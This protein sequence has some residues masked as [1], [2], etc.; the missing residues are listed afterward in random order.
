[1]ATLRRGLV[2]LLPATGFTGLYLLLLSTI[3]LAEVVVAVTIG[4]VS[5]AA[6]GFAARTTGTSYAPRARWAGWLVSLPGAIGRDTIA[7]IG[8][9]AV[10]L[11]RLRAARGGGSGFDVESFDR[12]RAGAREEA[13]GPRWRA[14]ATLVL[15]TAPGTYVAEVEHAEDPELDVLVVHR[16]GEIGPLERRV[17]S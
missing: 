6:A 14:Y 4:L 13:D 9:T 10:R 16:V 8:F 2:L 15:S 11:V 12:I 17:T 7:V 3:D 5:A 1:M